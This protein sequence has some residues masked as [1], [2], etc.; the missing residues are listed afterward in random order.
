[1]C[2]EVSHHILEIHSINNRIPKCLETL[3]TLGACLRMHFPLPRVREVC[4]ALSSRF[5]LANDSQACREFAEKVWGHS[6]VPGD[7]AYSG[8]LPAHAPPPT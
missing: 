5:T 4:D 8:R 7:F 1:M 3:L 6:K 2:H